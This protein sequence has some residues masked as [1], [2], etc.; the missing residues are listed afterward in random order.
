VTDSWRRNFNR[1][2]LTLGG[3]IAGPV[4]FFL[5]GTLQGLANNRTENYPD[6]WVIDGVETCPST[7]SGGADYSSLCEAGQPAVF[8]T[9]RSSTA[10]GAL[11]FVDLGAP[12]LVQFDNARVFPN[13]WSQ[14]GLFTAN[15]NWQL[16]R[17][18]R[19]NFSFNRN[20]FQNFQ[21]DN[22]GLPLGNAD[23]MFNP[24][25]I[26]GGLTTN[27][28]FTL[29]WFQ[30]LTQTADQQLA[31]ELSDGPHHDRSAGR[32]LVAGQ[33]G[34]VPRI[35]VRQRKVRSAGRDRHHR[36]RRV[37]RDGRVPERV[38]LERHPA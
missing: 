13:G 20:R 33:P 5:A 35:L 30:T 4:T 14:Q 26:G 12:N 3:P 31:L 8:E 38:P 2:E 32:E 15:I 17:G 23:G 9:A 24:D 7:G 34:S 11:D 37:H 16:P 6:T 19:L 27:N 22:P 28:V 29:G 25:N 21:Q 18:S 10:P 1:T 36:L